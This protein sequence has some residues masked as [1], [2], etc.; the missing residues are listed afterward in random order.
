M[1][2]SPKDIES[3]M[4]RAAALA[5][6]RGITDPKAVAERMRRARYD[7]IRRAREDEELARHGRS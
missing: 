5:A 4:S 1:P 6:L 7:V 2:A 3:A